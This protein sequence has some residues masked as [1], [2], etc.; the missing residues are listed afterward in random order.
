MIY[1]AYGFTGRLLAEEAV[2]RG[3]RPLLAGR[4]AEKLAPMAGRLGLEWSAIGLDDGEV[5]AHTVGDC[6]LVLHAAGPFIHTSGPMVSACI[7]TATN[8]ID[9]TGELKVMQDLY[10]HDRDA[11]LREIALISGCGF[12]V[13]PTDCLA[14]YL[15]S[16]LPDAVELEIAVDALTSPS[17][18]TLVSTL[19]SAPMGGWARRDGRMIP[20][21]LGRGA[22]DHRFP[23][24]TRRIMPMPLGDLESAY[25]S[26]GIPT[27]TTYLAVPSIVPPMLRTFGAA[28]TS[29]LKLD[30]AR[31]IA[32]GLVKLLASGPDEK[33]RAS[34]KAYMWGRVRNGKGESIEGWIETVEPYR[35][36]AAAAITIMEMV[37]DE[38]PTGALTPASAFGSDLVLRIEASRRF[39]NMGG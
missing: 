15:L 4:S 19:E 18:G 12:D 10:R 5:L 28:M 13:V 11:R 39:E 33:A 29:L 1:G 30:A 8:Y 21:K 32:R 25:I 22:R 27:I 34:N 35:F 9:I 3:Y 14:T 7:A 23:E 6:D 17:A 20:L 31:V 37:L 36:T 38:R 24:G 26:T 16:H 2:R